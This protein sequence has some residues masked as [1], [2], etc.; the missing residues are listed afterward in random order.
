MLQENPLLQDAKLGSRN[1]LCKCFSAPPSAPWEIAA[2]PRQRRCRGR[3]PRCPAHLRR[4]TPLPLSSALPR[5]WH[6]GTSSCMESD[7]SG[8]RTL[9]CL[10]ARFLLP[11]RILSRRFRILPLYRFSRRSDPLIGHLVPRPSRNPFSCTAIHDRCVGFM[12]YLYYSRAPRR[13]RHEARGP[14]LAG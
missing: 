12:R 14:S 1:V 5:S 9:D 4:A 10:L 7:H 2:D 13:I 6:G 11:G 3:I 8:R